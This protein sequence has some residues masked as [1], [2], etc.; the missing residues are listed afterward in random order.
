MIIDRNTGLVLEGGGMRGVF[1]SGVLDA[2]MSDNLYFNYIVSVSAGA[3]NGMSY[4]SRQLYRARNSNIEYLEKYNYLS[5][6][7]L[8]FSGSIFDAELLYDKFPNEYL[9][10]DFD[11]YFH[12]SAV[13]EMV[14][15]NC[16][17][18]KAMYLT[19][20][21][22][23]QRT[24]DI[25]QAS[26]SLPFVSRIVHVDGIPM[27]DGGI[28][29]SIPIMRAISSGYKKNVIVLTRNKGFRTSGKEYKIP[30]FLY[31][32]YPNLR[33]TLRKRLAM[34][35]AQIELIEQL[36]EEGKVI[37]IRPEKPLEVGRMEKNI[38]KLTRLY[39]EGYQQGIKFCQK[40]NLK[41]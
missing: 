2:F 41:K 25:V 32:K 16:L 29:D 39:E 10:F 27:L 36:E 14:T 26:S 17:T 21:H 8:I 4:M 12:N 5:V 11:T 31:R 40:Y 37:C 35:N 1:T 30:F 19:E 6:K 38:E 34:Y 22:D 3:C 28:A 15:T 33:K 23:K 24:L 9:P 13:F 20:K 18:G 7:N